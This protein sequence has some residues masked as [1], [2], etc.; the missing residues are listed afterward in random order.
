MRKR[1][2]I[3]VLL[4]VCPAAG[5]TQQVTPTDRDMEFGKDRYL[6]GDRVNVIRATEGDVIAAGANVTVDSAVAGDVLVAGSQVR[7][8]SAVQQGVLAA[9]REVVIAGTIQRNARAAG[10]TIRLPSGARIGRNATLA[11]GQ[12]DL[13]GAIDGYLLAVG[14]RIYINGI[15]GGDAQIVAKQI[16]LGPEAR[17]HGNL[18]YRSQNE[19]KRDPAAQVGGIVERMPGRGLPAPRSRFPLAGMLVWSLGLAALAALLVVFA[20]IASVKISDTILQRPGT[21]LLTG[22]IALV[23]IPVALVLA[24]ITVIGIPI[25]MLA[26]L[27]YPALLLL[28][29]VA[30]GIAMGDL[31]LARVLATRP[32][33]P[34]RRILAAFVALLVLAVLART[35]VVGGLISLACAL[36]GAGALLHQLRRHMPLHP[37]P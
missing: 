26:L 37:K 14:E 5:L 21:S 17:I 12:L 32:P 13:Q 11:G 3:T 1:L 34:V 20:P 2:L 23:C 4:V 7:L 16:E 33:T 22:F 35:P 6:A 30:G 10:A 18:R 19:L 29:Y 15:V 9:G 36:A 28:G 31:A 8:T 24:I 25:G 27:L